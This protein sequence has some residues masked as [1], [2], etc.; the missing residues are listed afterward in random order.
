MRNEFL[1]GY[2][3]GLL[4]MWTFTS[5]NMAHA[6]E[7]DKVQH[8]TVSAVIAMAS[9][10]YFKDTEHPIA[11]SIATTTAVGA[12]KEVYDAAHPTKHTASSADLAAD[13]IGAAVGALLADG[14]LIKPDSKGVALQFSMP[15]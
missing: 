8:A 15:F 3:L 1:K 13:F 9:V 10:V 14:L 6:V 7:Q 2:L 4:I 11:Y 12:A 5:G